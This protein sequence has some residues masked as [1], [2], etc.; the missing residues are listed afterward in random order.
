MSDASASAIFDAVAVAVVVADGDGEVT[1]E[2][3]WVYG[4]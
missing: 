2:P 4:V 3:L 1:E